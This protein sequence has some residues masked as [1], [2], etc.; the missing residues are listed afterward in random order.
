M[1]A[2]AHAIVA[3]ADLVE[4]EGRELRRQLRRIT[5]ALAAGVVGTIMALLGLGFLLL[6]LYRLLETQM[7]SAAAAAV[8]GIA[9]L[10]LAI[11]AIW[12]ARRLFK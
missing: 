8:F 6:A 2:L 9:A 7:S 5:F 11:G 10:I 4:A 1:E 3:A 12:T